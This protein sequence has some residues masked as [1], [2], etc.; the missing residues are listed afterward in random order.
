MRKIDSV[1]I[2]KVFAVHHHYSFFKRHQ[3]SGSLS[4]EQF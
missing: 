1:A 2:K 3:R 4:K